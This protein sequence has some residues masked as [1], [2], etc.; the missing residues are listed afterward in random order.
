MLA[1]TDPDRDDKPCD[2]CECCDPAT[3]PMGADWAAD[4]FIE[5]DD[6]PEEETCCH[7]TPLHMDCIDCMIDAHEYPDEDQVPAGYRPR[8]LSMA[9]WD[10][11]PAAVRY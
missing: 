8:Y 5:E 4:Q 10:D 1:R 9:Y 6:E 7:G 3:C 2:H 11:N